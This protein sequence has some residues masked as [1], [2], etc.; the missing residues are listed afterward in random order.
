M[1]A[2]LWR[3]GCMHQGLYHMFID[4]GVLEIRDD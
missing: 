3:R 4:V 1:S 2:T